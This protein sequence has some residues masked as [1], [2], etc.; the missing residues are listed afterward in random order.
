MIIDLHTHVLDYGHWAGEWWDWAARDWAS[1]EPGRSPEQIRDKIESGLVD[2]DASRMIAHMDASGVDKAVI[3]PIDW[4]PDYH[5]PMPFE[6]M[7]EHAA[8]CAE[9]Y[10]DR[11]IPFAGIDPRRPNAA[12]RVDRWL[13][14]GVFK[15]LKLYPNCGYYPDEDMAMPV[16]EVCAA[17]DVPVL[18]HTGH[19]LPVLDE[20]Y[21]S[22]DRYLG[23]VKNFPKLK[24]ILGHAGA[25]H[26]WEQMIAVVEASEAAV[27]ELSLCIWHFASYE[28]ELALARKICAA[29]D[30]VGIERIVFGSDHVSGSRIRPP[31]A[32]EEVIAQYR[33]LPETAAKV[34]GHLSAEEHDMIMYR[35]AARL[36]GYA[37]YQ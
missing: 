23:V 29:R 28:E 22:A 11:L 35:N 25:P 34:G 1:K 37:E 9:R 33:R 26:D 3:L 6:Q 24:V 13:S 27:M 21:S 12:E 5:C 30:R 16:Y 14:S 8:Q 7:V 32:L 2:P 15:G 10:P 20:K 18:F 17:H 19:P 31:G 4:G 36:L